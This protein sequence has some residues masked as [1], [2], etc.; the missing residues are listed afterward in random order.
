MNC[1]LTDLIYLINGWLK[2]QQ[3]MI[4]DLLD[5]MRLTSSKAGGWDLNG[6]QQDLNESCQIFLM[7]ML[8]LHGWQCQI[9]LINYGEDFPSFAK[10]DLSRT[11]SIN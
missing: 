6:W 5:W 4:T 3:Q 7:Q 2:I 10:E 11:C 8:L 1:T 9:S